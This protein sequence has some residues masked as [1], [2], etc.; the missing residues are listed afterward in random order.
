M[1]LFERKVTRVTCALEHAPPPSPKNLTGGGGGGGH[2]RGG[3]D[4]VSSTGRGVMYERG[5]EG[6][7]AR[8]LKHVHVQGYLA[9]KKHPPPW[10]HHRSRGIGLLQGPTGGGFL[11]ARYPCSQL[12][13]DGCGKWDKPAFGW[14]L[15]P[16]I[17][18][19]FYFGQWLLG[20]KSG[21]NKTVHLGPNRPGAPIESYRHR[22][23]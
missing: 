4:G 22:P 15:E 19:G 17:I 23:C 13:V 18:F 21:N 6:C 1:G 8:I 16:F 9:H 12:E 5:E 2:G 7:Q 11:W 3:E 10:D 20:V 14:E